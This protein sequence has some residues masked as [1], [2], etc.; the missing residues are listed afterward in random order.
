LELRELVVAS[1]KGG[2][3]KTTVASSLAYLLHQRLKL[4]AVDADVDAPDLILAL[5]GGE[6]LEE[7][8]IEASE[9]ARV[10]DNL[11]NGCGACEST[12]VYGAIRVEDGIAKVYDFLCEGCGACSLVCPNGAIRIEP[13]VTGVLVAQRTRHRFVTITGR[14]R[15]GEHNSGKLV[16]AAKEMA[17][18]RAKV[19]GAELLIVDAAPGI[20]CPVIASLSGASYVIAVAEPTPTSKR[21]LER[22]V[23][24]ARHFN[25]PVGLVLNKAELSSDYAR[26]LE[27]WALFN[28]KVPILVELPVDYEAVRALANMKTPPELNPKARISVAL[29]SLADRVEEIVG[30]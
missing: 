28:L 15:A 18:E 25:V 12:C 3:G 2:T 23:A 20:G 21:N 1:G 22:L 11:C 30:L 5:G 10:N 16:S 17:R 14:L 24:V 29:R 7:R 8:K 4:V 27:E 9:K 19:E 13:Y 26:K 6:K